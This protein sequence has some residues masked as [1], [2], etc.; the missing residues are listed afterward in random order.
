MTHATVTCKH[1]DS[2]LKALSLDLPVVL[3]TDLVDLLCNIQDTLGLVLSNG[4]KN[5]QWVNSDVDFWV[6]EA[7]E[8][9]VQEHIEP[10]LSEHFLVG[11][12]ERMT[13]VNNFIFLKEFLKWLHHLDSHLQIVTAVGV[14]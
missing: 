7:N 6:I 3:L 13:G 1:S 8:C 2:K 11:N 5:I 14:D 9:I 4:V 10:L 12:E